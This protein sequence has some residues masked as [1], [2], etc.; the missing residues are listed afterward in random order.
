M[1]PGG[2]AAKID[3]A[4]CWQS[5]LAHAPAMHFSPIELRRCK[6]NGLHLE[7]MTY[8][9]KQVQYLVRKKSLPVISV[10]RPHILVGRARLIQRGVI[11]F[12][13]V[14]RL[15]FKR[16]TEGSRVHH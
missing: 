3:L 12:Q 15:P 2:R 11:N 5:A 6:S 10:P 9:D 16:S 8:G 1:F 4:F 7:V 14:W 13:K